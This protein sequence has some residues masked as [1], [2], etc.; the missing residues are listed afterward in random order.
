MGSGCA[1]YCFKSFYKMALSGGQGQVRKDDGI[2]VY[3]RVSIYLPLWKK[4]VSFL[5]G[6]N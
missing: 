3:V 6:K 5:N 4:P 1:V 2:L